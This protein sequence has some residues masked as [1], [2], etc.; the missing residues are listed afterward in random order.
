M[1]E[2]NAFAQHDLPKEELLCVELYFEIMRRIRQARGFALPT[3]LGVPLALSIDGPYPDQLNPKPI[4]RKS[5][6]DLGFTQKLIDEWVD[7]YYRDNK[8]ICYE[9]GEACRRDV[10]YGFINLKSPNIFFYQKAERSNNL[11]FLKHY[12]TLVE[13]LDYRIRLTCHMMSLSEVRKIQ[14]KLS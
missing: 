13:E 14:E 11:I 4:Y 7:E 12:N 5:I 2:T 6:L 9:L 8:R 3:V 1:F 10:A